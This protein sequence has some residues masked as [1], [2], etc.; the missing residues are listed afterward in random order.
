MMT[1][2][3]AG[4]PRR[5]RGRFFL[6]AAFVYSGLALGVACS[7]ADTASTTD[8]V[9][10]P[11]L[12]TSPD[13]TDP[14][15]DGPSLC[16]A[17]VCNYQTQEGC[18]ANE[19]CAAKID[20]AT[21]TVAP[22]CI[23]AGI[24]KR[25]EACDD[26]NACAPGLQCIGP[27]SGPRVCRKLCCGDPGASYGDWRACDPGESCIRQLN[28]QIEQPPNSGKFITI[29]AN[30]DFCYPVNNCDVLNAK[31]CTED[32]TRPVCRIADPIGNVACQP[33]GTATLGEPC[34]RLDQCGPVQKCVQTQQGTVKGGP[35]EIPLACRR[36]CRLETCGDLGCP[37]SEGICVHFK[38]DPEGV[39]E[40]TPNFDQKRYCY[41]VDGSAPLPT[42]VK[43][44]AGTRDASSN[45]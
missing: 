15:P 12:C 27:T 9:C 14:P 16:P 44:D 33:P 39:G 19:T 28:A 4:G 24:V 32:K 22:K 10:V 40:C 2:G 18:A 43:H 6:I 21:S 38:R 23:P 41:E 11:K 34:K 36:L 25:G 8:F 35:T 17:G 5:H 45:G 3:V 29:P 1:A 7:G 26:K 31:S 30:V 20:T 37:E 13:P 42:P